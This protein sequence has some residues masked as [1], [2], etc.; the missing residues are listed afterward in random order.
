LSMNSDSL[1][2][3]DIRQAEAMLLYYDYSSNHK[4]TDSIIDGILNMEGTRLII[5]QMNFARHVEPYQYETI[6]KSLPSGRIPVIEPADTT[7]RGK[8]GVFGLEKDV[9]RNLNWGMK[10]ITTL[11]ERVNS[12]KEIDLQSAIKEARNFLPAR[13]ELDPK[14]FVVIGGRAGFSAFSGDLIYYDVQVMSMIDERDNRTTN[15][16]ELQDFLTHE[17]HHLGLNK[18]LRQTESALSLNPDEERIWNVLSNLIL[19][20]SASYLI[21]GKRDIQILKKD[22]G[23]TSYFFE[24]NRLIS[25]VDSILQV[26]SSGNSPSDNEFSRLTSTMLGHAYHATGAQIVSV[27]DSAFG[28]DKV[29]EM[30]NDPRL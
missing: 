6:L 15:E 28:I 20:G 8:L 24:P 3:A 4:A 7:M 16:A 19:E 11:K 26:I 18:I 30:L 9:W 10:N 22:P 2:R 1:Q 17:I 12:C 29:M 14:L 13:V 23:F 5:R 27:I 25:R 21:N